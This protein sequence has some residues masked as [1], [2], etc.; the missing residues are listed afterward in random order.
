MGEDEVREGRDERSSPTCW[1]P[2]ASYFVLKK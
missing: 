1:Q 2:V